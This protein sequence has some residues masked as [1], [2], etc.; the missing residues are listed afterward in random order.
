MLPFSTDLSN[1]FG[2][3]RRSLYVE[4][5]T[6]GCILIK[7]ETYSL[8]LASLR[9]ASSAGERGQRIKLE[10]LSGWPSSCNGDKQINWNWR[11]KQRQ[12]NGRKW[13]WISLNNN[14][15]SGLRER[16]NYK[17]TQNFPLN[18]GW[19]RRHPWWRATP[20]RV[21]TLQKKN[22]ESFGK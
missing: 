19:R 9:L 7:T 2:K 4:A 6:W 14:S 15:L 5:K 1:R 21:Q 18:S 13:S 20:Q 17:C 3:R 10:R 22:P 11:D 12:G 16:E 8:K